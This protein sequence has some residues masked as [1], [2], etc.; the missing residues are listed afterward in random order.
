L[1]DLLRLGDRAYIEVQA[2]GYDEFSGTRKL[3]QSDRL[4]KQD[5]HEGVFS[6]DSLSVKVKTIDMEKDV[7]D[8][9]VESEIMSDSTN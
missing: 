6:K 7:S 5:I 1:E 2:F 4:T 3:F 8:K 9:Q